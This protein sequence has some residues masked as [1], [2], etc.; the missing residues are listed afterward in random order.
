MRGSLLGANQRLVSFLLQPWA[1]S[2]VTKLI[3]Y[4][5]N[6][7]FFVLPLKLGVLSKEMAS[8]NIFLVKDEL[9]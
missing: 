5:A 3:F 9:I 1:V 8:Q 7:R 2:Q 6:L 4:S